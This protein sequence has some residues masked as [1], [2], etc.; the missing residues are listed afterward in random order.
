MRAKIWASTALL[1]FIISAGAA[2]GSFLDYHPTSFRPLSDPGRI[3]SLY[4]NP[5]GLG[6]HSG[7][8]F[9]YSHSHHPEIF[10]K[11][12]SFSAALDGFAFGIEYLGEGLPY[13]FRRYNI[14]IGDNIKDRIFWGVAYRWVRDGGDGP[15][16]FHQWEFGLL[17]RPNSF[18][19]IGLRGED[20]N[21]PQTVHGELKPLYSGGIS[22]RPFGERITLG[23]QMTLREGDDFDDAIST[24]NIEYRPFAGISLGFD[25][26]TEEEYGFSL[27]FNSIFNTTS[28]YAGYDS[29][30]EVTQRVSDFEFYST[31]R[32]GF[33]PLPDN[34]LKIVINSDIVEENRDRNRWFNNQRSLLDIL[35]MI[36]RAS[37]DDNIKGLYLD[38]KGLSM[39]IASIQELRREIEFFRRQDKLVVAYGEWLDGKEYYLASVADKVYMVP[40]GYLNLTGLRA[41]VTYFKGLMDKLGIGAEII[42]TGEYKTGYEVLTSDTMSTPEREQTNE[43]LDDMYGK[44]TIDLA[45]DR[46]MSVSQVVFTIDQ[47]PF[48]PEE[49][50]NKKLIDGLFYEHQI[51]KEIRRL[52][53]K[54]V[55]VIGTDL[56][57]KTE[58]ESDR[59]GPLPAIAVVYATGGIASGKSSGGGFM[60]GKTC[61]S[62]TVAG[63]LRRA[64]ADPRIKAVVLRVDSPGGEMMASDEMLEAVEELKRYKPFIMSIGDMAASGGY[65]ISCKGDMIFANHSSVTGSIG[66]IAGKVILK[67]MYDKLGLKNEIITRGENADL[68]SMYTEPS[69]EQI[70]HVSNQIWDFYDIFLENVAE[71]RGMETED[72]DEIARGRVWSGSKAVALNLVDAQGG[73][74]DAIEEA[75]MRAEIE[76]EFE[77]VI[78][79]DYPGFISPSDF[80]GNGFVKSLKRLGIREIPEPL[81]KNGIYYLMPF[82]LSIQ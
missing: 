39:G 63:A 55:N 4:N 19:S 41:E 25:Y 31:A 29:D 8:S 49:A 11:N 27:K 32:E 76:E 81:P 57:Q 70:E 7:F 23:G 51:S 40:T 72:V 71:G 69:E 38:V 45:K 17:F 80:V 50:M 53:G 9:N 3:T 47:G 14:G 20:L 34:I 36:R 37:F 75:K 61:G 24:V 33:R 30:N 64:S 77:L 52:I 12:K 79:P 73:L 74:L 43:L 67:G 2:Y 26:N 16:D 18:L 10:S 22:L 1:F 35:L 44:F 68:F 28:A 62:E 56:Y 58:P 65:Y 13:N 60:F 15:G 78:L 5:A 54:N 48:I 66:V 59:W 42:H 82:R 21:K 46:D 6:T